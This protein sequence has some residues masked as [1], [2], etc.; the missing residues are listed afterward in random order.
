MAEPIQLF[1]VAGEPSG[2]RIGADLVKRLRG[3]HRVTLSG[4]GGAELEGEGLKS[5]FPMT[6]LSVM[7]LSDVL[8][9]LPL[10]LWSSIQS[11]RV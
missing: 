5:L 7:G 11:T 6:D 2:D 8:K 3:D 1:M 10:L 9:R 4:V